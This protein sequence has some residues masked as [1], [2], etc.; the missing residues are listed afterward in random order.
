[1]SDLSQQVVVPLLSVVMA[2]RNESRHV[3]HA[4]ESIV[5]QTYPHWELIV[6]DDGSTDG[7]PGILEGYSRQDSRIC[8]I[9]NSQSQGLAASLNRGIRLAKGEIVVRAD[10]DDLNMP[11]RFEEQLR[12]LQDHHEID[13]VGAGA[14]LINE[15][16]KE[17]TEY[18]LPSEHEEIRKIAFKNTCFFH[19]T[20]AMRKSVLE[21][22]GL[23]DE[24]FLRAQDKEL[25]LRGLKHGCRYANIAKP[26]IHYRITKR[27][28]S[29]KVTLQT[30][31]SLI[32]IGWQY[33]P[34]GWWL[35]CIFYLGRK[36]LVASGLYRPR[37]LR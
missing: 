31:H 30:M 4:V 7:T 29:Y 2:A 25:W 1:M 12:Y 15:D 28:S 32:R 35:E 37:S 3:A 9:R 22:V 24:T 10:A 13:F 18:F 23:Y 26:L 36:I 27:S 16:G 17:I 5:S 21:R 8:W 14:I 6:I 33:K 19:P 20:V 34:K 11:T